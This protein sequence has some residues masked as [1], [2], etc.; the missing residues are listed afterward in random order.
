MFLLH[1]VLHHGALQI[2]AGAQKPLSENS[3]GALVPKSF[4]I[5]MVGGFFRAYRACLV[6]G[7]A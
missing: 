6:S 4:P 5:L 1:L 7:V 2:L 3:L